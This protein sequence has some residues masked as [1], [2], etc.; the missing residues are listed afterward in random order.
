MELG[1]MVPSTN[2]LGTLGWS[3]GDVMGTTASITLVGGDA[4]LLV[5][6]ELRLRTLEQ[7]WSRFLPTSDV[8]RLNSAAG[9]PVAVDA[10]TVVLVE[11]AIEGWRMTSGG[12][13]ATVL[14]AVVGAGYVADLRTSAPHPGKPGPPGVGMA[15]VHVDRTTGRVGLPSGC[16]FD[17]GGI[18]KGLAADLVAFDL[19]RGGADGGCVNVGGDLRTW[20]IAPHG[21]RWR[22]DVGDRTVEISGGGIATSGS[23]RRRW[24]VDGQSFHHVVDSRTGRPTTSGTA[25]VTVIANS[26]WRAECCATALMAVAPQAIPNVMARWGVEGIAVGDDGSRHPTASLTALT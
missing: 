7:R 5:A 10:D 6:A 1:W 8:S 11:R 15:G 21:G 14:A 19:R 2:R 25:S 16:G 23:S 22:V 20:G 4:G 26:G 17:P 13:D 24:D 18:G 3:A 9:R 12:F